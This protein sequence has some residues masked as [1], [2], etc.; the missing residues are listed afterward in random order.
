LRSSTPLLLPLTALLN[1][2]PFYPLRSHPLFLP[3]AP[4]RGPQHPCLKRR[5]PSAAGGSVVAQRRLRPPLV[6]SSQVTQQ[7]AAHHP[8]LLQSNPLSAHSSA[9]LGVF[10]LL[11]PPSSPT[12]CYLPSNDG[13]L[14]L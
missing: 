10:Q 3:P 6:A 8:P 11:V 9:A 14:F 2:T 13:Q 1:L 4:H 7:P 12:S 5:A